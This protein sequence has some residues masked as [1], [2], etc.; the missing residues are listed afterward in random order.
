MKKSYLI[1]TASLLFSLCATAQMRVA[2]IGGPQFASV[3]ETNSLGGWDTTTKPYFSNRSALQ[4]GFLG[5]VPL[6]ENGRFVFMP[7]MYFS[8]KG[9]KFSRVYPDAIA[10]VSDTLS[11]SQDFFT[12]Y[13]EMPLNLGYKIPLGKKSSFLVS[14]GPYVAFFIS[15]KS[16]IQTRS[17]SSNKFTKDESDIQ[18]GNAEN[19]VKTFDFGVNARAGFDLGKV[20]ITGHYSM[21]LSDFY[22]AAYDGSF[23]HQVYGASLGIWLNKPAE[24]KPRDKDKDGVADKDDACP[25][26]AGTAATQGCP[27]QDADGVADKTDKCPTVAGLARY[28][29]CPIPDTDKDGLNDEEDQCPTTPGLAKYKGCPIPDTDKDGVNDEED[30]CPQTPGLVKY[31]GCP[32]PDTDKDG[33]NDETDKCPEQPGTVQNNG[34]PEIKKEIVEKVNYAARNIFFDLNSEKI[35]ARSFT[36]LDE[37]VTILNEHPE[38]KMN[39][40]GHTDNIG[41]ETYNLQLSQRRADAVKDYFISK[42]ISTDR[43][44]AKGFGSAQPVGDNKTPQGKAQN[45]RVVL[46]LQQ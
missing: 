17:F 34:C 20:L 7:G 10:S 44:Q 25:D 13:V 15:G 45:R 30:Q 8:G 6:N 4:I 40:E 9:R 11:L 19:K 2:L 29:G 39:I 38:L 14:A 3:K 26:V 31:K 16:N 37:V 18:V 12:N 5:E 23:K 42:G 21:G 28:N 41:K 46:T 24:I 35:L 27:D 32:V 1:L 33:V 36:G 43:L 22:T